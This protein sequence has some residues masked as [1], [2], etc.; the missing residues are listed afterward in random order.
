[1]FGRP[2]K[3]SLLEAHTGSEGKKGLPRI[4]EIPNHQE[5]QVNESCEAIKKPGNA[6]ENLHSDANHQE[7]LIN[8]SCGAIKKEG[9]ADETL[10]S[11]G[12]E[13]KAS[14]IP[15]RLGVIFRSIY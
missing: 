3:S 5:E 1:M 8:E 13:L 11:D 10:H 14:D 7:E 12:H 9:N 2:P 6:D 4:L 15:T